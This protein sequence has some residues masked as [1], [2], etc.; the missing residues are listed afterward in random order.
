MVSHNFYPI[1]QINYY[2]EGD[3]FAA[4]FFAADLFAAVFLAALFFPAFLAGFFGVGPPL[5]GIS[6]PRFSPPR[7]IL[8]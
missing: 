2:L 4:D 7:H 8:L 3:F 1:L 5:V 6:Y